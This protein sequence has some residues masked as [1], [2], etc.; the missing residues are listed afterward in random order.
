[1]AFA[2]AAGMRYSSLRG[3]CLFCV[4]GSGLLAPWRIRASECLTLLKQKSTVYYCTTFSRGVVRRSG[5]FGAKHL[6]PASI[7]DHMSGWQADLVPCGDLPLPT[8]HCKRVRSGGTE[9]LD[10]KD[11]GV[12]KGGGALRLH[13]AECG[14]SLLRREEQP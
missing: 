2:T 5:G 12:A 11:S 10:A 7:Y 6:V 8:H 4:V 13:E 3:C 9:G 1:M 14:A